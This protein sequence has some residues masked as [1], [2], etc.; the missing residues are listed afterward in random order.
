MANDLV[1]SVGANISALEKQMKAA[2]QASERA[3]GEIEDRFRKANPTIS[4]SALTGALKGFAAAFTLDKMIRGIADANADL[5]RMGETAKRV[6]LDL[7]R[8][9]ELQFA[10]RQNG[11]AGKD[12]GTGLEGLAE[13]LN[14]ARQS[15]NALTKLFDDNNVK[16][17]DRKGEVIG[18]NDALGQV[19]NLV[20]N[21]ATE[22][23]KIK[24]AEAV[25][26]T[27][28]WIPL[29]EQGAEA[30]ARQASAAS[31]AGAVIDSD[32]IKKAKDFERDWAIAIDRWSTLFKANIGG[33]IELV[34]ALARKA[35]GLLGMV[36][37]YAARVSAMEDIKANGLGASRESLE[38]A[39]KRGRQNGVAEEDL[40]AARKR[41]EELNELDRE[42][43][44]GRRSPSAPLEVSVRG[45]KHT[46]TSSLFNKGGG[47]SGGGKSDEEQAQDRLDRYIESLIRQRAVMEA[48]IA[49][50]GKSNAE[51]KAAVE[52]AKAQ[53]DLDK[54]SAS[55]KASYIAKLTQEVTANEAVRASKE[56][57]YQAQKDLNEAQ[58]YFGNAAVDALE[59]LIVNGAK[60]E[61]VVKRLAASLAKAALQAA[62]MGSGPLAGLFGTAGANGTVGGLFGMLFGSG[63]KAATGGYISGPGTGR[64]DSI[65]ARLSNG[66]YVVNA[67]ATKQNR[68]L[69]EAI[70]SGRLPAFADGGLVG[71]VPSVTPGMGR[72]GGFVDRRTFHIDARGAQAGVAEQIA[73]ALRAYDAGLPGKVMQTQ[74]EARRRGAM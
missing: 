63:V 61:D 57:L 41:I 7:Q 58:K 59:D 6:G 48:E 9:Q 8:F 29:L 38:Y 20:R 40:A 35:S 23:D 50:V 71:R 70:N 72:S 21:A 10:G 60:A 24:I 32:V 22:F 15:E 30:I 42:A 49:T 65:Q 66:E 31:A 4:T 54:L 11:L 16:L 39:V 56:R 26:L 18:I 2:A 46:D 27:R 55:E 52:I 14:E 37:D 33:V 69:L 53:V 45:G 28:D 5:V 44:R 19:A 67:R 43:S 12:F 25:G 73:A 17:K 51:R 68:A 62:L 36:S 64:S 1:V 47:S 74:A 34:D 13:K 3:A